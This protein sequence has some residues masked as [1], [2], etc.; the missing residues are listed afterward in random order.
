MSDNFPWYDSFWL[1]SYAR[2]KRYVSQ[3]YPIRLQEFLHAFDVL[4]TDPNF[5]VRRINGALSP[6]DHARLKAFI[7]NVSARCIEKHEVLQFGRTV[8]HD[9]ELCNELQEKLVERMSEWVNEPVEP[10]YNFL[11]LYNNLGICGMHL[12]APSAKWT[13][14]YCIEQSDPW[15]IHLSKVRPWPETWANDHADW[16]GEVRNDPDNQFTSIE[17][18][19]G[20]AIIF[21]GSSQWHYRDRITHRSRNNF[22]HL[23]FFHYVPKGSEHLTNPRRW[24]DFFGIPQ[25]AEVIIEPLEADTA[26]IA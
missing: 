8:I 1:A 11:S 15:P 19:E 16:E 10:C 26:V 18:Q 22:C 17:L 3:H 23:V 21:S 20:E 6:D 4:R 7:A 13:F 9:A 12:D 14:D 5:E 2:A 25:L 24:G